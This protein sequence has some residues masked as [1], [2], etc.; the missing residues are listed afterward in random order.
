MTTSDPCAALCRFLCVRFPRL[1]RV[2]L[3]VLARKPL[4][5]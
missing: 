2:V 1:F 5:L 4:F 3:N